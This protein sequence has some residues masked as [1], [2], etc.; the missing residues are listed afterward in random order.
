[1][2]LSN[3]FQGKTET[4]ALGLEIAWLSMFFFAGRQQE[5]LR[6]RRMDLKPKKHY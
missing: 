3:S 1:M 6:R 5:E 2:W 4:N